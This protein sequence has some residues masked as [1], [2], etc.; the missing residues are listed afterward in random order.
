VQKPCNAL[1]G[2]PFR[3]GS[4][5]NPGGMW[6]YSPALCLIDPLRVA[7][8]KTE[9]LFIPKKPAKVLRKNSLFL[10]G[11]DNRS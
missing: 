10:Q 6:S 11:A 7:V 9:E 8:M 3:P 5:P 2:I 1:A 4:L